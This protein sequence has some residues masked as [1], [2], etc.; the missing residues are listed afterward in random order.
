[1]KVNLASNQVNLPSNKRLSNYITR[2][3]PLFGCALLAMFASTFSMP[4]TAKAG[5]V[6]CTI[7]VLGCETTGNDDIVD[8]S[9]DS[10]DIQDGTITADDLAPGLVIPQAIAD[11]TIYT[12]AIQ[13]GAV[14][15]PK[16]A[17][18]AVTTDKIADDAV[19]TDKIADDAVTTDKIADDAV[20]TDKIA[21]GAV[22][23][24]KLAPGVISSVSI[25]D[26]SITTDK[27]ADNA[28]TFNKLGAD[29]QNR[30]T[31]LEEDV[32]SLKGGVAMALA[33]ANAPILLQ[34][35]KTFSL[36]LGLGFYDDQT[37]GAVKG[38][39]RINNNAIVTGSLAVAGENVGGGVGIGI[40]F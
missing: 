38:A 32:S 29:V 8:D 37:A 10:A 40:G 18:G 31:N 6:L 19:T 3:L 27:I 20:T 13:D 14:T 34:G 33:T 15:T 4:T 39:F 24:A 23:A 30:F 12:D 7:I 21:D 28:V 22:T 17:D 26:D 2:P 16:I 11:D 35:D 9:I 1:M 25:A 36:S 5:D